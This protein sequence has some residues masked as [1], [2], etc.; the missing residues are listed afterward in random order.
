MSEEKGARK[1]MD[2]TMHSGGETRMSTCLVMTESIAC[3]LNGQLFSTSTLDD[4]AIH[5]LIFAAPVDNKFLNGIMFSS[6]FYPSGHLAESHALRKCSINICIFRKVY[7]P[8]FVCLIHNHSV[9]TNT[10]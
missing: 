10:L 9:E 7:G 5:I 4:S 6:A 2:G 8:L 3:L 1:K